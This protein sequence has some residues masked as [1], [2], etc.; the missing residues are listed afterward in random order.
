MGI[1]ICM[2]SFLGSLETHQSL[3]NQPYVSSSR[4]QIIIGDETAAI[5]LLRLQRRRI[6]AA[7]AALVLCTYL[8]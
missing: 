2:A 8:D 7:A 6:I 5:E 4:M 1:C 3:Y